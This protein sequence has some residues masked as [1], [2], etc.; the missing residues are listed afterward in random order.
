MNFHLDK[1]FEDAVNATSEYFKLRAVLIEK[2]YWVT[3]VLKNLSQS[4]FFEKVIFKGGTSLSKAHNCIERFSEDIDLALLNKEKLSNDKCYKLMK[5][6]EPEITKELKPLEGKPGDKME[7]KRVTYYSYHR[8]I[9]GEIGV[10]KDEIQIEINTFTNPVPYEEKQIQSFVGQ[11]LSIKSMTDLVT[12]HQLEPFKLLV[13]TRERTFFEKLLSLIRLSYT[14]IDSL[15]E[16]IR[17]FYDMYKLY[18]Q[19]DLGE[20]LFSETNFNLINLALQD[21]ASS[22]VFTGDWLKNKLSA[23]PLFVDINGLW[24]GLEPTYRKELGELIWHN[25]LPSSEEII[26]LLNKIR[27]FLK[28]FDKMFPPKKYTPL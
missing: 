4:E 15:R 14:G 25:N 21:D 10:V 27:T 18:H 12:K 23:S 13:L 19:E 1:E 24:K 28:E 22:N 6:I 11:F 5:R 9:K 17:H 2:D 3:Y 20:R 7:K 16:K 8:I 26:S